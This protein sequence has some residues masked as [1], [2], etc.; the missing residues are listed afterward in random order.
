[1][2]ELLQL[3]GVQ[4]LQKLGLGHCLDDIDAIPVLSYLV[5]YHAQPIKMPYPQDASKGDG[6]RVEGRSFY[7]GK[8]V[9]ALRM[10]A[11]QHKNVTVVEDTATK[12]IKND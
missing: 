7:H 5:T 12:L 4:A 10:A 8:F 3:G 6:S 11:M 9:Q 1:M 2:G